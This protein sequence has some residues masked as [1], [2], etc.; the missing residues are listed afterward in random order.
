M[1]NQ[2]TLEKMNQMKLYGMAHAFRQAMETGIQKSFTA[3]ELVSPLP[4]IVDTKLS[5]L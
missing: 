5:V 3:D 2:A 1:N 4:K